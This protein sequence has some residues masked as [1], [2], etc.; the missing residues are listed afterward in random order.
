MGEKATGR[1]TSCSF[2]YFRSAARFRTVGSRL[3]FPEPCSAS[4][5]GRAGLTLPIGHRFHARSLLRSVQRLTDA[6][7]GRAG[8]RAFWPGSHRRIGRHCESSCASCTRQSAQRST[9]R[10]T[11]EILAL[12][13]Q[14]V[15]RPP[16]VSPYVDDCSASNSQLRLRV[17]QRKRARKGALSY[18]WRLQWVAVSRPTDSARNGAS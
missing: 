13:V 2:D 12:G 7:K 18:F 11:S 1:A 9:R 14:A 15:L 16:C 5:W 17:G 4:H 10:T 8:A 6:V 3:G